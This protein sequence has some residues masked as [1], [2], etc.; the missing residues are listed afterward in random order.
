[1]SADVP[2]TVRQIE[3][4]RK[5]LEGLTN[6]FE[7]VTKELV[8]D[9][10]DLKAS[11]RAADASLR[12]SDAVIRR[13]ERVDFAALAR[14]ESVDLR[15]LGAVLAGWSVLARKVDKLERTVGVLERSTSR[16]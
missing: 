16:R 11:T 13:T 8:V 4:L 2:A 6:R 15:M 12:R 5:D 3:A 7:K 1:M 10:D 14:L 9:L